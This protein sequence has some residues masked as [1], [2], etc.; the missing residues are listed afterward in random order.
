MSVSRRFDTSSTS[1]NLL[2]HRPQSTR[3][4]PSRPSKV[5]KGFRMVAYSRLSFFDHSQK[6]LPTFMI[7]GR[8]LVTEKDGILSCLFV[9]T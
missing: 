8:V 1:S 7:L 6:F 3:P 9:M 5:S 4:T 2:S